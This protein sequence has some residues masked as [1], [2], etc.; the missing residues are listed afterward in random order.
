[1]MPRWDRR[2]QNPKLGDRRNVFRFSPA[3]TSP[4]YKLGDRRNVLRFCP[5][6]TPPPTGSPPVPETSRFSSAGPLGGPPADATTP[7]PDASRSSRNLGGGRCACFGGLRRSPVR[8][9]SPP[10]IH[11]TP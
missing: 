1:M 9:P 5:V 11:A 7:F 10:G 3:D 8:T 4:G 2:T 6:F